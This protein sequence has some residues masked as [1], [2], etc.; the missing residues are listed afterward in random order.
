MK[1][2]WVL[3]ALVMSTFAAQSQ[4]AT[5]TTTTELNTVTSNANFGRDKVKGEFNDIYHFNLATKDHASVSVTNSFTTKGF[6]NDF[7][8]TL[9]NMPLTL[10]YTKGDSFQILT[11]DTLLTLANGFHQLI[12]SGNALKTASYGGSLQVSPV[13]VPAAVWLFGS[14][15]MGVIGVARRKQT[16]V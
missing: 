15:L 11:T 16:S 7:R 14:A 10:H 12:V 5:V 3:I 13:P 4:A 2:V 8:A 1:N 9:D 6:I